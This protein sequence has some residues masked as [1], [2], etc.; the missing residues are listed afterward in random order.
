MYSL[1]RTSNREM[2]PHLGSFTEEAAFGVQMLTKGKRYE[3]E[4][5]W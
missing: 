4:T 3:E 5:A 1:V 2:T